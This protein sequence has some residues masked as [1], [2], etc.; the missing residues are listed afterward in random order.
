[1]NTSRRTVLAAGATGTLALTA[2][3]L[4]FVLGNGPLELEAERVAPTDAALEDTGYDEHEIE[5]QSIEETIDVG[6]ERDVKAAAWSSIYSKEI[7][8]QGQ[9]HEG[10][11]FAAISI[12]D[13][14]ALGYSFNPITDMSNEELLEEFL[15]KLDGDQSSIE[16][17]THQETVSFEILDESRDIDI[18]EGESDLDGQPV[19]VEIKITSFEHDGDLL[20]LLGSYPAPL[21]DE[22]ANAEVLMESVEHPV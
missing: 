14:S 3:C 8:Y 5:Q 13:I 12:P 9:T 7:E 20:V 2:G 6:I 4:D 17:I 18:F 16:N 21:G 1:M 19:D 22:S 10:S 11:F 15:D